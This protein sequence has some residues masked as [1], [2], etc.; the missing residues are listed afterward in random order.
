MHLPLQSRLKAFCGS[1]ARRELTCI[2]YYPFSGAY[3]HAIR[4]WWITNAMFTVACYLYTG[5]SSLVRQVRRA[6]DHFFG[7][8]CSPPC[9]FCW[10]RLTLL[11]AY[12]SLSNKVCLKRVDFTYMSIMSLCSYN[13]FWYRYTGP[14]CSNSAQ[15]SSIPPTLI[16]L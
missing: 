4:K 10:F 6:P 9:P 8:V 12:H 2:L 13:A 1:I 3:H 15:D 14:A 11:C 7:G 16:R 5:P